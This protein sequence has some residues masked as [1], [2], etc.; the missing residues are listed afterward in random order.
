MRNRV[1]AICVL[2]IVFS[3]GCGDANKPSPAASTDA[4]SVEQLKTKIQIEE[5]DLRDL[6]LLA[7]QTNEDHQAMEALRAS[8]ES[9]PREGPAAEKAKTD[10]ARAKAGLEEAEKNRR[11]YEKLIREKQEL[12]RELKAK[13]A[14]RQ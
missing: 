6:E 2:S 12:I 10:E 11:E 13:L 8:A 9:A 14:A 3:V 4:M 1:S 7:Q 5:S